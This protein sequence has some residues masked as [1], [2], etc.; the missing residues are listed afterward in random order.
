MLLEMQSDEV[1]SARSACQH[2]SLMIQVSIT[3]SLQADD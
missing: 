3:N 2:V 1:S